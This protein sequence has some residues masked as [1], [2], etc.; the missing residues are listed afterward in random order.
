MFSDKIYL[1]TSDR[2]CFGVCGGLGHYFNV[3]ANLFRIAFVFT[4]FLIP[5]HIFAPSLYLIF[6][7]LF[8]KDPNTA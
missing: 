6:W 4:T 8:P 5:T 2:V 1:S 3:D 7:L